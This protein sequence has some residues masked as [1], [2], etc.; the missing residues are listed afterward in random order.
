MIKQEAVFI[1]KIETMLKNVADKKPLVH[2]IT[3]YVTV[4]DC[5]NIILASG[6]SPIMADDI[7]EAKEI[8][9]IC[10]SL[11]LNIGTL[12]ER[13]VESM[14][15]SG[16]LANELGHPVILDPVGAGA[17]RFRTEAAADLMDK[18]R[19][20]V[21]RGNVS[22]IRT[23]V[24]GAGDTRGVDASAGSEHLAAS[25]A[26]TL[27]K[28]SGAVV[29]VT[30]KVDYV[31]DEHCTVAVSN[32]HSMMAGITGSGCMLSAVIGA[33]C[34]GNPGQIFNAAV[35][36]VAAMGLCGELAFLGKPRGICSF[37]T[38]LIDE[39]SIMDASILKRGIKL[40]YL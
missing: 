38:G 6:G 39:M 34:G 31:A 14:I 11:V 24:E 22:E 10:N 26:G 3:N 35:S 19:F 7:R 32:G 25:L 4:N 23:L 16:Q 21:I 27:A 20:S 2:C 9:S 28:Q 30:G 5:A 29:A 37:R 18:I 1:E 13:T 40:E 33:W 36:A 15:T 17:S 12:N 8:T